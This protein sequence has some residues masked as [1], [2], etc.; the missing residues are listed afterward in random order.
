MREH[1]CIGDTC[2]RQ[3]DIRCAENE[4]DIDLGI[5]TPP[6]ITP[7]GG[8]GAERDRDRCMGC[9]HDFGDEASAWVRKYHR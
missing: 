9:L 4:C 3:D 1:P 6:K 7:C 2:G 5:Y 8:C